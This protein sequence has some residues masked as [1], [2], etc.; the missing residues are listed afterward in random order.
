M[1]G[2]CSRLGAWAWALGLAGLL[3]LT[4]SFLY[5]VRACS[6]RAR[7]SLRMT[8]TMTLTLF[9]FCCA[10]FPWGVEVRK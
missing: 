7:L 3:G 10:A 8:L 9:G 1:M 5:P 6:W 2:G 4:L